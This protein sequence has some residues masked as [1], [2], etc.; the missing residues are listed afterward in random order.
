[1]SPPPTRGDHDTFTLPWG[2]LCFLKKKKKKIFGII[3]C[4]CNNSIFKCSLYLPPTYVDSMIANAYKKLGLHVL[5]KLQFMVS[6]KT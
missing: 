6:R 3:I 2:V 5:K 4:L 1:M